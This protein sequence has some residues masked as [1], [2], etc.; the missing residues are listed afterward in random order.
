MVTGPL[1]GKV[2]IVTGAGSD[3]GMGKI[4]ALALVEAGARVAMMEINPETLGPSAAIAREMGGDVSEPADA[5]RAVR[6]TVESLGGLH[7]LVNNAGISLR[8]ARLMANR[9]PSFWDIPPEAW[10]KMIS[11]NLGGAFMMARAAVP[12]MIEQGWGRVIGVTTSLDTMIRGN[13]APYGPSKAGHEALVAVMAD[14]LEGTGVSANVLI[15]GGGTNTNFMPDEPGRD[16]SRM[17]QPEVMG[18]PV[19]WLASEGSDGVNGA[20][21]IAANW[22]LSLELEERVKKAMAPVAW[23]QLGRQAIRPT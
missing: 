3:I 2:A 17:I 9:S 20:R 8:S 15:P 4:M 21:F 10:S 11:V 18:P 14:E 16:R 19:V 1:E 22:D 12:H 7:I 6:S 23:P 5:E 13:N